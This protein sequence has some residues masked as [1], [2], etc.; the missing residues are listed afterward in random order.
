MLTIVFFPALPGAI[1]LAGTGLFGPIIGK[2][3]DRFGCRKT[4][5]CGGLLGAGAM[6]ASSFAP[7]SAVLIITY[8]VIFGSG[9]CF[10]YFSTMLAIPL[11]FKK[12][13]F[14]ATSLVSVGPGAALLLM[15]PVVQVFYK[16][17]GWR[18]T[19]MCMAALS[20]IPFVVGWSMRVR[21]D[22]E[23]STTNIEGN[24][25]QYQVTNKTCNFN[26]VFDFSVLKI[27]NFL[28]TTVVT[29]VTSLGHTMPYIHIV[30]TCV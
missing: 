16:S 24:Q 3:C 11:Y 9:V 1:A 7:N 19:M 21:K 18:K 25:N 22:E 5:L 8:G 2:L 30:S 27:N 4:M 20:L 13:V 10:I 12:Y 29:M 14:Q 17:F 28:F 23:E 15:S 6:F 26:G